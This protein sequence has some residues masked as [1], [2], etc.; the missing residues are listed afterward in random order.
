M[1]HGREMDLPSMQSLRAKLSPDIRNTD[2]A[3][4]LENL[5]SRLRRACKLARHHG[6]KSHATNK[7]YYDRNAKDREFAVGDSVYLYNPARKAGV[8][9]K[10]RRL[11]VGPWQVIERR[12]RLNYVIVDQRGK[13]LVVH[14]NRLKKAY[15]PVEWQVAA[16]PRRSETGGR[17]KR[18]LPQA[19]EEPQISSTGPIEIRGPL[20]ENPVE[21]ST[22]GRGQNMDTPAS[23]FSPPEAPSNHRSDP[24]YV[25][26]DTTLSRRELENS[27]F[28]PPRTR[29]RVR[30]HR[31]EEVPEEGRD[32]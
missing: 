18:W 31:L 9:A 25:P 4:R 28:S 7:Q 23:D 27:R 12:S 3:P 15:D 19:E 21:R 6:R 17:P 2:H 1:L 29:Y 26:S 14:I 22:P 30:Q 16:K 13:Q 5:K 11:W 32:E 8:S 10:F 24:T 20:I